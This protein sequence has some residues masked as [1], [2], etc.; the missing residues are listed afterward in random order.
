MMH[1]QS[2]SSMWLYLHGRLCI[3]TTCPHKFNDFVGD[4]LN[5]MFALS[6]SLSHSHTLVGNKDL[7]NMWTLWVRRALGHSPGV[8]NI[9]REP[10]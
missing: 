8:F 5:D 9:L 6:L 10:R 3:A 7:E 1:E 2:A 4:D